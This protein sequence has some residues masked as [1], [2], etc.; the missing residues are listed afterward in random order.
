MSYIL[1]ALKKAEKER[2]QNAA[3][4]LLAGSDAF[5]RE[6]VKRLVWPYLLLVALLINAG[7]FLWLFGPWNSKR[8]V[9]IAP[10]A[11]SDRAASSVEKVK[12]RFDIG[13]V[14]SLPP[15]PVASE[16]NRV[17]ARKNEERSRTAKA[18]PSAKTDNSLRS[19]RTMP[20]LRGK[21]SERAKP[22]GVQ[23]K[24]GNSRSA[25]RPA[26]PDNQISADHKQA[27]NTLTPRGTKVYEM[28][29]L[30]QSVL[31]SLPNLS[32]SL[33]LYYADPSSR[34]ISVKGRT[35]REGQELTPGLK[36]EEINPDGAVFIFQNYR[37]QVG[38]NTK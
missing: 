33:H 4:E 37:F 31:S 23:E 34:L 5:S 29:E 2:R 21:I 8:P 13:R 25:A 19:G 3:S 14:T 22:D 7:L 26:A 15:S 12:E 1:D 30:P 11:Q 28:N 35:L 27:G 38:L 10:Q 18:S 6:P 20:D 36:L 24:A 16:I 32:L 9:P 17:E